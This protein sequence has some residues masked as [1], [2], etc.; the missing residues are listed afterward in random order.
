[1]SSGINLSNIKQLIEGTKVNVVEH[2]GRDG[3]K[4]SNSKFDYNGSHKINGTIS[5][6]KMYNSNFTNSQTSLDDS[7]SGYLNFINVHSKKMTMK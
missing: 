1:M 3:A 4:P 6:I 7:R 2:F 5:P